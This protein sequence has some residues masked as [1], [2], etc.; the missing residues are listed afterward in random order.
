MSAIV[1]V[2]LLLALLGAG[3]AGGSAQSSTGWR[4]IP[5]RFTGDRDRRRWIASRREALARAGVPAWAH[6]AI[7][8]HW[9]RE[10]GY[11][12]FEWNHNPGNIRAFPGAYRGDVV[13]LRGRDGYLPYRA[14]RSIDDG[15]RDYWR[16][17]NA[18]RYRGALEHLR[19]GDPVGWY[20]AIL[21]AGYSPLTDR[22]I[23]EFQ[24][25]LARLP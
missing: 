8:A 23:A 14:H 7:I 17:L 18:P 20:R 25:I 24:R 21:A 16:L 10:T 15:V 11:G 4:V 13:Y 22:A 1:P 2:L 5:Q 19:R 12:R 3:T 9:A 6:R